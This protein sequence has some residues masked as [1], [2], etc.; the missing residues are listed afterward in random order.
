MILL[1]LDQQDQL[2]LKWLD[3]E[4]QPHNIEVNNFQQKLDTN[5]PNP[6]ILQVNLHIESINNIGPLI[7][8]LFN[9]SNLPQFIQ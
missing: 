4:T 7:N 8:H 1:L 9:R 3:L 5:D 6:I 2:L